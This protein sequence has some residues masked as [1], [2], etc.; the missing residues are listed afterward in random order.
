M[1]CI[2]Y[3]TS[4][5]SQEEFCRRY[6]AEPGMDAPPGLNRRPRRLAPRT[7]RA[8]RRDLSAA[9]HLTLPALETIR[10]RRRNLDLVREGDFTAHE[11][12]SAC[13]NDLGIRV[14]PWLTETILNACMHP[15]AEPEPALRLTR[16]ALSALDLLALQLKGI[17]KMLEGMAAGADVLRADWGA[18]DQSTADQPPSSQS[19]PPAAD[20]D[21]APRPPAAAADGVETACN[22]TDNS[23]EAEAFRADRA[24]LDP[25]RC[26]ACRLMP[27]AA[28]SASATASAVSSF[29]VE[30]EAATIP[31]AFN[32]DPDCSVDATW[33]PSTN[34][35]QG[36][37]AAHRGEQGDDLKREPATRNSSR[38]AP[39]DLP[40][41]SDLDT[42]EPRGG[43][44]S[45]RD[46]VSEVHSHP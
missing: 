1:A 37:A 10:E 8:W 11:L 22:A 43:S 19:M 28:V 18:T 27:E 2:R 16:N 31:T 24:P 14:E 13:L 34:L 9:G 40:Q 29:T 38:A 32:F 4:G 45:L 17:I 30:P 6:S 46:T 15:G 20:T 3:E 21:S 25:P 35:P 42:D 5:L 33:Q 26:D 12:W 23:A 44:D 7:L 41:E 39:A 36:E